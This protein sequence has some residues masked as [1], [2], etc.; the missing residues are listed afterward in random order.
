M[1]PALVTPGETGPCPLLVVVGPTAVGK[2]DVAIELALRLDGEVLSADAMQVYRGLDVGTDK[3]SLQRQR[4]VPHH[5]LDIAEPEEPFSA[6]LYREAALRALAGVRARGKVAIV[7]GGTGLYLRAFVDDLV[8]PAAVHAPEVR[9]RLEAEAAA[10]GPE[11]LYR[12]LQAVDPQAAARIHPANVRRVIRALE[13]YESTGR[14]MSALQAE[15]RARARPLPAVWVGLTRPREELYRRIDERVDDQ[16]RRGLVDETRRL[17]RRGLT[18]R[19]TAMQALGYKEM[20]GYLAGRES[21]AQAVRRLKTATRHYARRQY[22]WFRPDR[23]IHW[24]DLSAFEGPAD[25]AAHI[26]AWFAARTGCR[27]LPPSAYT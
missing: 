6:V 14:P 25:T 12:R 18:R 7:C 20:A 11:V 23:R 10:A 17:L 5:L 8:P 19:H 22:T 9:A 27:R 16:V 3:P 26:A 24:V 13:V 15:S 21:F 2:T 4:G 1:T